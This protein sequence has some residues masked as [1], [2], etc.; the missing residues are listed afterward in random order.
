MK[1]QP[2]VVSGLLLTCTYAHEGGFTA[3]MTILLTYISSQT[4]ACDLYTFEATTISIH[5]QVNKMMYS[6]NRFESFFSDSE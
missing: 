5:E 1:F 2:I 4:N 3:E 6:F